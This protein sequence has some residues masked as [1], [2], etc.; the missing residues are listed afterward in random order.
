MQHGDNFSP[1]HTHSV[2]VGICHTS[3][4]R[5][6][7]NLIR[8]NHTYLTLNGTT[9]TTRQISTSHTQIRSGNFQSIWVRDNSS[10][11]ALTKINERRV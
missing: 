2:P 4:E 10:L 3:G 6:L 11:T 5:Y 9:Q 8:Y 7:I 1:T